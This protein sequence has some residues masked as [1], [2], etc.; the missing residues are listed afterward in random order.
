MNF[1]LVHDY[2]VI[3]YGNEEKERPIRLI[4]IYLF[5]HSFIYVLTYLFTNLL[6]SLSRIFLEKLKALSQSRKCS[7][8]KITYSECVCSLRYPA[9]NDHAPYCHLWPARLNIFFTLTHKRKIFGKKFSEYK[10]CFD[11][12]YNF[13]LKYF[14][15]QE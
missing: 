8:T 6:T 13:R 11:F 1:L 4:F 5:T 7:G 15:I 2:V 9:C 10:M 12:L 14:S 3:V